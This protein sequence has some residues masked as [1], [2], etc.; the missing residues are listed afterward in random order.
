MLILDFW[1]RGGTSYNDLYWK[2]PPERGTF[3]R[4]QV[5]GISRIKKGREICHFGRE[6]DLKGLTDTFYD[7]GKG[8]GLGISFTF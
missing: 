6:K 7:C 4:F 2:A 8:S 5:V 3:F 1:G